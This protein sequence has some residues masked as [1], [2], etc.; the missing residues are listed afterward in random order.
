MLELIET[1]KPDIILCQETKLDATVSSTEVFPDSFCVF[2]HDRNLAG[3]GVCIAV[4]KN[5]Q[6]IQCHDLTSDLEAVWV[7]LL[8]TDHVPVYICSLYRP[9]DKAPEYRISEAAF[10]KDPQKAHQ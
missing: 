5:L 10:R 1:E 2:R 8:T 9:P 4:K 6:V 3:G 7:C